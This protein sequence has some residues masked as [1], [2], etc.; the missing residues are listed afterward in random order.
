VAPPTRGGGG[1]G[2]GGGGMMLT[3]LTGHSFS[4]DVSSDIFHIYPHGICMTYA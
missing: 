2:E 4:V 1:G 3:I